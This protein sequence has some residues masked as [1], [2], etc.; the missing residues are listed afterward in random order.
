MTDKEIF[1]ALMAAASPEL[2]AAALQALKQTE[3]RPAPPACPDPKH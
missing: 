3:P 1:L 2:R